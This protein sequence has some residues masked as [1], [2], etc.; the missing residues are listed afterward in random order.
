M[1][2][3][4]PLA[5]LSWLWSIERY[6]SGEKVPLS[7]SVATKKNLVI[8]SHTLSPGTYV[9]SLSGAYLFLG[10]NSNS[11]FSVTSRIYST[12]NGLNNTV[13]KTI[14]VLHRDLIATISGGSLRTSS[15]N[16]PLVIDATS[17]YDPDNSSSN[18][19]FIWTCSFGGG[20]ACVDKF[21]KQLVLS[22]NSLLQFAA[23]TLNPNACI[24]YPVHNFII[25]ELQ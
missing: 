17:S 23:N 14:T 10:Y 6:D 19:T 15:V 22:S 11:K 13:S 24:P 18:L 3:C 9:A 1:T 25:F 5:A 4:K 21:N 7:S 16:L 8:S 2:K 12:L 20:N